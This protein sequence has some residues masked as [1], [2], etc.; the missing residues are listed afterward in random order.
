MPGGLGEMQDGVMSIVD[1]GSAGGV[2]S[3]FAVF[4][5]GVLAF[6]FFMLKEGRR[7][8]SPLK[9]FVM[10]FYPVY[11]V[12]VGL[13]FSLMFLLLCILIWWAGSRVGCRF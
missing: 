4:F 7:L 5:S 2:R 8:K 11:W 12:I 1:F 6:G 3:S 9:M 10:F 13:W